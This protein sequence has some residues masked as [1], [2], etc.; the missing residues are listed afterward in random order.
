M[1]NSPENPGSKPENPGS[2][3]EAPSLEPL[4]QVLSQQELA[5]KVLN[6]IGN[7]GEIIARIIKNTNIKCLKIL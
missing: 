4:R 7:D 3:P 5:A 1:P 2:K 6:A